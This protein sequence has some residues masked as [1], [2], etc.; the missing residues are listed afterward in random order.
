MKITI[1][2]IVE[3]HLD[4]AHVEF[5][6]SYGEGLSNFIGPKPVENQAHDVE[7][8]IEDEFTWNVNI[9]F[10][11]KQSPS[12]YSSAEFLHITGELMDITADGCGVLRIGN[13]LALIS[14]NPIHIEKTTPFFVEIKAKKTFLYPTNI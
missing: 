13:S 10:S 6:T 9:F 1:T 3:F 11:D 8:D 7:I 2:R 14:L 5:S 4:I 12:I